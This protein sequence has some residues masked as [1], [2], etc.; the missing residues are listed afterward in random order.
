MTNINASNACD[1]ANKEN[2]WTI[3]MREREGDRKREKWFGV[4]KLQTVETTQCIIK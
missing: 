1:S 2:V 3:L 4:A